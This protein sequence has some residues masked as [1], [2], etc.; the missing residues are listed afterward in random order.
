VRVFLCRL[1]L[2][3]VISLEYSLALIVATFK[4][5]QTLKAFIS[6][7]LPPIPLTMHSATTPLNGLKAFMA[8]QL[9]GG[10]VA[11]SLL[12]LAHSTGIKAMEVRCSS[13]PGS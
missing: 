12:Y 8:G 9:V 5:V 13:F 3:D 4:S 6:D 7:L 10:T 1:T 11:S 2:E